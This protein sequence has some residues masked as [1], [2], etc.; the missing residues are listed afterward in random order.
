VLRPRG[1]DIEIIGRASPLVASTQQITPF[2]TFAG[3]AEEAM[4]FYVS[5]FDR[6]AVLSIRRYGPNEGGAE[7]SVMHAT[8]SLAGQQF[9]CIDSTVSHDWTF[10]PAI[11]L[12]VACRS[13]DEIDRLYGRLAEGGQVFMPLGAYPFSEKFVWLADRFG[14]SWQLS[15]DRQ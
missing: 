13:E 10:T 11:S 9:M 1:A 6:S 4:N 3:Q 2:L 15:L 12:Y 7:G 14:V 5:L 8:F